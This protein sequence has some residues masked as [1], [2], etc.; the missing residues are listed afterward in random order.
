[1]T[2]TKDSIKNNSNNGAVDI[3]ENK[4]EGIKGN[5]GIVTY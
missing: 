3:M 4:E 5:S 1:M 2:T